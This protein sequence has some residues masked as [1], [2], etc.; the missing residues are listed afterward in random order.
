MP[1]PRNQLGDADIVRL[2]RVQGQAESDGANAEGPVSGGA[3][4][5]DAVLGEVVDDAGP[6]V[7]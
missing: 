3:D 6:D 4:L 7:S 1:Q 2:E 5:G